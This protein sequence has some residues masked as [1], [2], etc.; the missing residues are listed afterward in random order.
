MASG[1]RTALD[2]CGAVN[3]VR[4]YPAVLGGTVVRGSVLLGATRH[5]PGAGVTHR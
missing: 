1:S 5:Q 4:C 3:A 2:A